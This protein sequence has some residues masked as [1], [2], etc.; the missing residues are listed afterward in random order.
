MLVLASASPRRKEL[1]ALTGLNVLLH[2]VDLDE[3]PVGR[4][5]AEALT[6]RLARAK[7]E[8]ARPS[9][10]AGSIVVAADTIVADEDGLLGKPAGDGEARAM[11]RRL[12]GRRHTV[13]TSLA[14]FGPEGADPL[15]DTCST[16]VPMR[17][18]SDG[19]IEAFIASGGTADKA[20]AYGIQDPGFRPVDVGALHG[21]FAN[22]MGLPLC[23]LV[24]T[25]RR[26]DLEPE[27]DV[28]AACCALT[29]YDC[30]VFE[31]IL[32]N[33]G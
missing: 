27:R 20:G 30:P 26:R 24:R 18:Y 19:E 21:C 2:S 6:R 9:A 29:G 8:A 3:T 16:D 32:E 1:I 25:L 10:P 33:T 14:V 23:H 12:R 22:V 31:R 5:P 13:V 4:E 15:F 17:D 7:A 28:P 11:L